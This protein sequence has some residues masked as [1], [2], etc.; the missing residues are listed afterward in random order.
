MKV[1]KIS[2]ATIAVGGV[3][4]ISAVFLILYLL[5]DPNMLENQRI[6]NIKYDFSSIEKAIEEF[7]QRYKKIPDNLSELVDTK[8]LKV[9][10]KDPW[11]IKYKY[12]ISD[13]GYLIYTLGKDNKDGGDG[14]NKDYNN[15][16]I[17]E[18]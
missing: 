5:E 4:A 6:Y 2:I 7:E 1:L 8:I 3:V 18:N 14:D 12:K 11:G 10:P 17:F 15:E 13:K 16:T 9:V